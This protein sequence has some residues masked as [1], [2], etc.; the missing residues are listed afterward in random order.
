MRVLKYLKVKRGINLTLCVDVFSALKCWVDVSYAVHKYYKGYTG[1]MV[2]LGK[3]AITCFS[4]KQNIQG[5]IYI[6][7][8]II[9]TYDTLP[10]ALWTK[11]SIESQGYTVVNDIIH[12]YNKINIVL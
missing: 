12:Q 1:D 8:E 9:G 5:K 4:I 11:Y 2:S 3:V 7:D 6:E 10:Q